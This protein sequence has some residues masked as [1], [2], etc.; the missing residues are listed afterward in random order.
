MPR[1]HEWAMPR[2][3]EW[4]MPRSHEVENGA[5]HGLYVLALFDTMSKI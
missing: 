1:S 2:S 4:A 3:H 5:R